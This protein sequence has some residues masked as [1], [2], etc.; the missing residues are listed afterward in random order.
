M[1]L[2][3]LLEVIDYNGNQH[4]VVQ[5]QDVSEAN[6]GEPELK[7]KQKTIEGREFVFY[8]DGS[9]WSEPFVD[10]RGWKR[11]GRFLSTR[12][13]AQ[14]Y[15]VAGT[16]IKKAGVIFSMHRVVAEVML[17]K[18]D[19][20][21]QVDHVDGDKLNNHP[22]NLRMSTRTENNRAYKSV[23]VNASSKYRG[24]SWDKARSRWEV[25]FKADGVSRHVGRYLRE[26][27]AAVAYDRAVMSY[28]FDKM[29]L[30]STNFPKVAL[31][32]GIDTS[33]TT[34]EYLFQLMNLDGEVFPVTETELLED[35][36]K[37]S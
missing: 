5:I 26:E 25:N 8:G 6:W 23:S 4:Q 15:L 17:P 30:N 31:L 29:A 19:E 22:S 2:P 18:W 28:G 21:L 12:V 7:T 16:T 3:E 14:G 20:S 37:A 13:S 34:K 10:A 33:N 1:K 36:R 11:S 35:R 27:E 9:V 24:V 32:S